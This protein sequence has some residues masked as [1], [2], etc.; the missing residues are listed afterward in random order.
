MNDERRIFPARADAWPSVRTYVESRC[1]K[2]AIHRDTALRLQLIAEELFINAVEH[3]YQ[4]DS[5]MSVVIGLR[6]AGAE[7]ELVAEDTAPR[8]NPFTRLA[9]PSDSTNPDERPLG[10]IG[11]SLVAGLS[12][13]R[14]YQRVAG[15]NRVTVAV[16]KTPDA[17]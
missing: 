1:A 10:G 2:L 15:C 17:R 9:A 11:R 12:S 5:G 3:G 16:P 8:F 14:D 13:R 4:G 7:A 6:D